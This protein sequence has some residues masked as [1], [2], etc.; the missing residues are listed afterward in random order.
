MS[1]VICTNFSYLFLSPILVSGFVGVFIRNSFGISKNDLPGVFFSAQKVLRLAVILLA[2]RISFFQILGI[3]L[4]G[5]ALIYFCCLSS[6]LFTCWLGNKLGIDRKLTQLIAS[7]TSICGASAILVAS[8][9]IDNSE[10]D[11]AYSIALVTCLGTLAMLG[12]PILAGFLGLTPT[13]FGLWCG[14]SIH[15]VAQVIAA[16]FQRGEIS[17]EI[18][19]IAKLSRVML[20]FPLIAFLGFQ[21]KVLQKSGNSNFRLRSF[22]WFV[23]FFF[24]LVVIN[25]LGLVPPTVID[26]IQTLNQF[27]LSMA[28]AAMGLLTSTD[29]LKRI[30]FRPIYLASLSWLFLGSVSLLLLRFHAPN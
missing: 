3:G 4:S 16:S 24:L 25:S 18:A 7:G 23:L 15:E 6:F 11:I 30:G 20:I 17:G 1:I 29:A 10:E 5:L 26:P 9:I 12:Y 14:T 21:S 28:M 2:L 19:T 27:L 13:V 8:P 22:P